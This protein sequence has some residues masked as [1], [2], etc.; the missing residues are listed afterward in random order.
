MEGQ[1]IWEFII[2]GGFG[3]LIGT[4]GKNGYLEL[5]SLRDNRI[6]LGFIQGIIFGMV[7][8]FIG[9]TNP[10]N[11]FMWGTAGTVVVAVLS[12]KV[13]ALCDNMITGDKDEIPPK[14]K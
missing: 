14:G 5:P 1:I 3:G 12:A 11:A 8:G 13:E 6:Y 10:M 9:D 4:L 7:G 2:A